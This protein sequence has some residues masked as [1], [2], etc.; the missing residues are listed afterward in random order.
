MARKY[1]YIPGSGRYAWNLEPCEEEEFIAAYVE[2]SRFIPPD[3]MWRMRLEHYFFD[4]GNGLAHAF[5]DEVN[6]VRRRRGLDQIEI[7]ETDIG[8][9]ARYAEKSTKSDRRRQL[10]QE[11]S[12]A[13]DKVLA[14][15]RVRA[16]AEK[17]RLPPPHNTFEEWQ[18]RKPERNA[19]AP[20]SREEVT[21][22]LSVSRAADS[23]RAFHRNL[24]S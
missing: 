12:D 5:L 20:L 22:R 23:P 13:G 24:Q 16:R 10:C 1:E 2:V 19:D 3:Q 7:R 14:E 17:Q 21:R 9:Y 18:A 6:A 11:L 8:D 4:Q 15:R